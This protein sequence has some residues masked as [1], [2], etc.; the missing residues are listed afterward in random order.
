MWKLSL[1]VLLGLLA[2]IGP[3]PAAAQVLNTRPLSQPYANP[4]NPNAGN[5]GSRSAPSYRDLSAQR[6]VEPWRNLEQRRALQQ[7]GLSC[8][9]DSLGKVRC[10]QGR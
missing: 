6:E 9:N 2:A 1:M 5:M 3:L 8:W 10:V 7:R 4:S